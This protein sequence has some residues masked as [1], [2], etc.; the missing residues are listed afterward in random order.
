PAR[1]EPTRGESPER[2]GAAARRLSARL[3]HAASR[4]LERMRDRVDD[5]VQLS[6]DLV[7]PEP[8]G[9]EAPPIEKAVA[10]RVLFGARLEAVLGSVDFDDEPVAQTYEIEDVAAARRLT[11]K[12]VP[13]RA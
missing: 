7:A 6:V 13:L 8:E 3:I 2:G 5:A 9:A 4:L 11:P 1:G 10:P 12:V